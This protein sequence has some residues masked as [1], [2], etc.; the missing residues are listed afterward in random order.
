M[1]ATQNQA[2]LS[3]VKAARQ[4][5][6]FSTQSVI[7]IDFL[8]A[9]VAQAAA[10]CA[11]SAYHIATEGFRCSY[12]CPTTGRLFTVSQ[13]MQGDDDAQD[14]VVYRIEGWDN[15]NT[16]LPPISAR[17]CVKSRATNS[18]VKCTEWSAVLYGDSA[19]A[20]TFG[21]FIESNIDDWQ[22]VLGRVA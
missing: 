6:L 4:P 21:L 2:P 22:C 16:G 3:R 1:T 15:G 14:Y 17:W 10:D 20:A 19:D 9:V 13:I 8:M 7:A 11:E 18:L 12:H 5:P